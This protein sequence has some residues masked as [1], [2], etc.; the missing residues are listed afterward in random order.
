MSY[1]SVSEIVQRAVEDL[2]AAGAS[3]EDMVRHMGPVEEAAVRN[4]ADNAK[5]QLL[6][7]LNYKT[8]D[9]AKRWNVCER[10]VRNWREAAIERQYIAATAAA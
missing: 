8:V 4:I 9:L 1:A 3:R 10:T 6:L 7:D 5:A 2:V